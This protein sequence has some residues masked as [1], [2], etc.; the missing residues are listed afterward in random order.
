ML[1]FEGGFADRARNVAIFIEF[2]V[3]AAGLAAAGTITPQEAVLPIL[4]GLSTNTVSKMVFAVTAGKGRYAL[5]VTPG[6]VLILAAA[7]AAA[8][9]AGVL[10]V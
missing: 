8:V 10:R 6:L 2:E 4:L 5:A 1:G 3:D 7:W 9:F